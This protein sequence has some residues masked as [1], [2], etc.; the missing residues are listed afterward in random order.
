MEHFFLNSA[1]ADKE[2]QHK[3]QP[4][5]SWFRPAVFLDRDGTLIEDVGVLH[6][7]EQ[8]QL[9]P[10]TIEAL[11][12]L[13][14]NYVLFVIT[15][16]PGIACG[17][18]SEDQVSH[19]NAHLHEIFRSKGV[20]IKDWYVCPHRREDACSCIKPKPEFVLQAQKK[21]G[22]DLEKSFV[23][24]D[25]PHDV[26]TANQQ[27]VFG[28]YLLTGHGG[29]HLTELDNDR[30]V[31]H[32]ISDAAEWIL[33]HPGHKEDLRKQ[34][35]LCADVI[36][37]GGVAAFPTETVYGLGAD[38]F[39]SQ[40]VEQ[41]FKIKGRPHNNPLIV[42]ISDAQQLEDLVT[43]VPDDALR[44]ARQFWPGPLTLVLPKLDKV[45]DIVTGG[46][47]TV[48]V[49]M[50][51]HTIALEVI[52]QCRTPLAAP[53]ANRFTCT[54][55]TTARHVKEQLGDQ[56]KFMID[57]GA[58]RVGLESTVI[59]FTGPVPV[60]LRP[61]GLPVDEI[62]SLIGKV[63]VP[64]SSPANDCELKSPGMMLHHYAPATRL[65][66]CSKIPSACEQQHDIGLLLFKPSERN[67]SGT[68]EVLSRSGDAREAAANFFAALRRL[69]ALG[70]REIIAEF[71]PDEGLGYSINN[72]LA[73]AA[74]GRVTLSE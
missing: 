2:M 23:I 8:I 56:C 74:M 11:R 51:A 1:K 41:I 71:A 16:Q 46:H 38:I 42:H 37:S 17:E 26:L 70:L 19:V 28:L 68:V 53:S 30:L 21:Y 57:G 73:K 31:F 66:A 27:G 22:L 61:G 24:G 52:R 44:L 59:S 63:Q 60:V 55:P 29:R 10:D 14:N 12:M 65:R 43:H 62:E 4:S 13:Q 49:R 25:H 45:P 47:N 40:A 6:S 48:A 9:Y 39:Q 15:N 20:F 72:R 67:F 69:D 34:I 64:P 35:S 32:R 50:P 3:H 36:R 58:C 5:E 54:S 18:L 7:I 33:N